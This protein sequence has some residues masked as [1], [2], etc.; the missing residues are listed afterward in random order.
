MNGVMTCRVESDV[1]SDICLS[2]CVCVVLHLP[3]YLN[4]Y[5]SPLVRWPPAPPNT[6]SVSK[7]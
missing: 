6:V 4:G 2:V 5:E 3:V 1:T 7:K